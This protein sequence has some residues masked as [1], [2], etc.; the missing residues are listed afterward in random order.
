MRVCLSR[1]GRIAELFLT[2]QPARMRS[3]SRTDVELPSTMVAPPTH[4]AP[5]SMT[6][7]RA[8]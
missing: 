3:D 7:S 6:S 2:E 4:F 5:L 8:A 1:V